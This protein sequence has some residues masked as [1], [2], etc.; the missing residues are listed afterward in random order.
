MIRSGIRPRASVLQH[1]LRVQSPDL[2]PRRD[3]RAE[4]DDVVVEERDAHL[5]R[6]RHRRAVEV[7]EHVV[8]EPELGVEVERR[9][10]RIV[11][12]GAE[13]LV[14]D[15]RR[16]RPSSA[17]SGPRTSSFR[18]PVAEVAAH[19]EQA[20]GGIRAPSVRAA[21]PSACRPDA[22]GAEAGRAERSGQALPAA[23]IAAARCL[24]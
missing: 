7:V 2:E 15:P 1:V 24:R 22:H 17:A 21:R 20:L 9:R 4:L 13:A 14:Q 6:V 12:D 23:A 3:R 10:E 8:D 5:E 19:R 16:A 11:R 18:E